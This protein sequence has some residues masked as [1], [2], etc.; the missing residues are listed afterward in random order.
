L[1]TPDTSWAWTPAP[2][3]AA[4]VALAVYALAWRSVWRTAGASAPGGP[5]AASFG[6]GVALLLVALVTPLNR[7]GDQLFVAHMAQHILL[8]DLVPILVLLGLTPAMLQRGGPALGVLQRRVPGIAHPAFALV[9]Y[10]ATLW[11]WH[12]P[13]MYELA[14]REPVAEAVQ[15]AH[16]LLAGLL[17]W[18]HLSGVRADRRLKGPA[19]VGYLLGAR[20]I[21]GVLASALA[22]SR[23]GLYDFYAEQARWWGLTPTDDQR[24]AGGLMMTVELFA[25]TTAVAVVFIRMLGESEEA[26]EEEDGDEHPRLAH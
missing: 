4:A 14:L 7:L 25:M 26:A 10:G 1:A 8:V 17:F 23:L 22:F 24:M 16:F 18:S 9:F 5:R 12:A 11:L 19:S 3:A 15:H 20:L 6:A 13:P 21:T 2:L